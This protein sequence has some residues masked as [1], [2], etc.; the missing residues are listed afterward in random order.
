MWREG[1][2]ATGTLAIAETCMGA[3][4]KVR[5]I[6]GKRFLALQKEEQAQKH[7]DLKGMWTRSG[8]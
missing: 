3:R 7:A 2:T 6:S 5:P 8:K 4:G 1:N